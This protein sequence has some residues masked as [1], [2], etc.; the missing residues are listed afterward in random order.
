MIDIDNTKGETMLV[1][2]IVKAENNASLNCYD[3]DVLNLF[4]GMRFK[5]VNVIDIVFRLV[6]INVMREFPLDVFVAFGLC[7]RG[8][9]HAGKKG[10]AV[11]I[12]GKVNLVNFYVAGIEE[13]DDRIQVPELI[14]I[15]RTHV[16]IQ[17]K[18]LYLF[19]AMF[20][21]SQEGRIAL[22]TDTCNDGLGGH[23]LP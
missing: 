5:Y 13:I 4:L 18:Y 9:E 19:L 17:E 10:D 16:F 21:N 8:I 22:E 12:E 7:E 20:E 15:V 11:A 2:K 1:Q 6:G 23:A 3:E 14:P